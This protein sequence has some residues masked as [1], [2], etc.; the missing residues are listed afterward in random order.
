M[1]DFEKTVRKALIDKD[2]TLSNLAEQLGISLAYLY[3]ILKSSRKA[4][5]QKKRIAELLN[6]EYVS[7]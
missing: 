6:F 3:D 2:M 7:E 4:E 5:H 1:N